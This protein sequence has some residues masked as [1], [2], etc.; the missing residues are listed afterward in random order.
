VRAVIVRVPRTR[1]GRQT[2]WPHVAARSAAP[3]GEPPIDFLVSTTA[4]TLRYQK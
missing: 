2:F 3:S 1:R 4:T